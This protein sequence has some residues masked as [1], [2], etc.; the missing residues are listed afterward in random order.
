MLWQ[1]Y[2]QAKDDDLDVPALHLKQ[3]LLA[4]MTEATH[5]A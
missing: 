5:A 2:A 1:E 3:A 4:R